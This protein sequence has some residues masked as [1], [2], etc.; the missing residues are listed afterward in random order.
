MSR[1]RLTLTHDET[2]IKR[3]REKGA[4][5]FFIGGVS[6]SEDTV[7]ECDDLRPFAADPRYAGYVPTDPRLI[8]EEIHG[9]PTIPQE[10]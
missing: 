8:V 9:E 5:P 7:H 10:D 3:L 6:F 1:Y 2:Q 4:L